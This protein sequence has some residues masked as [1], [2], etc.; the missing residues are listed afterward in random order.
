MTGAAPSHGVRWQCE[1][2]R[3]RQN[4]VKALV[5]AAADHQGMERRLTA[6]S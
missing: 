6:G 3:T 5:L 4:A 1:S 2:G